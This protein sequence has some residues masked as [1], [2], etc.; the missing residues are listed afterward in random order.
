[1]DG[2]EQEPVRRVKVWDGWIRLVHWGIVVLIGV[3]WW[4]MKFNRAEL[5]YLSGYAVLTLLLFRVAWGVAGSDTA[6][7]ARFLRSPLAAARHLAHLRRREQD[8]E[9]G[10]NAAG[11]WMVLVLLGLLLV[12]AT[13]GLFANHEPG[14]DYDAHGPLALRVSDAASA[15]LTGV[16]HLT[17]NL[18][19]LA[20]GLHVAAVLAYRLLKGQDLLRPMVTGFKSLPTR[21]APPRMGSP[22]L[23]AA[24][25]TAA[26]LAVWGISKLG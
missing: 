17:F 1:M 4:S 7:F 22:V 8:T 18:V 3:S 11:G 25:L 19:L 9:V 2:G 14:F 13:T 15:R 5:H 20:A 12:Q 26:A 16:H 23:A 24:F 10:H 21:L 6:R